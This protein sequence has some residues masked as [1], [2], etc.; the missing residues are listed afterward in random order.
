MGRRNH[1]SH[2]RS[3]SRNYS[4]SRSHSHNRN[5]NRHRKSYN[6]YKP[7]QVPSTYR[8]RKKH[9]PFLPCFLFLL[10]LTGFVWFL[11]PVVLHGIINIG[12]LT[13]IVVCSILMLYAVFHS[14]IHKKIGQIW[15]K[16]IG[17]VFL[18]LAAAG[19]AFI[20][21][22]AVV[23]TGFMTK[24]AL[25]TSNSNA[26]LIVLGCKVNGSS[27]SL[28]LVRRLEGAYT[29]LTENPD[30]ACILSGGQG[31]DEDITEAECMYRYLVQKGID[32][33]RL[34]KEEASTST[35]ENL[36]FSSKIIQQNNLNPQIA[37]ATNEF[38]QYRAGKIADT[39]GL[40][41]GAVCGKTPLYLFPT[42]YVRELYGILYEWILR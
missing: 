6:P 4:H 12:N 36:E 35:R 33:T 16:A 32:P 25:N 5:H 22:L 7:F 11:L 31:S 38:H 24:A 37:I 13:G 18:S 3:R 28:M 23:E 41:Y 8:R 34:Y 2:S 27:P 20:L 1:R 19:I 42:Y 40:E 9:N 14:G 29:Y 21:I 17:K 30:S 10:G 26:T 39:L 15:R